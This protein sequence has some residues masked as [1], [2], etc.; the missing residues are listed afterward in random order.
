M[1]NAV[2]NTCNTHSNRID[3]Y[4]VSLA[5][6]I[7]TVSILGVHYFACGSGYRFIFRSA[8]TSVRSCGIYLGFYWTSQPTSSLIESL[9][10]SN[11]NNAAREQKLQHAHELC[12]S[13]P[14]SLKIT[15]RLHDR[16][17][18]TLRA[19]QDS[20][21]TARSLEDHTKLQATQ[22]PS[23]KSTQ[24]TPQHSRTISGQLSNLSNLLEDSSTGGPL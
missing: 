13:M 9:G 12:E 17:K 18:S 4:N 20:A 10:Q 11:K 1:N 8:D 24:R 2:E 5:A 7:I 15:P 3:T 6:A 23:R 14:G 22:G 21:T 19:L 16:S